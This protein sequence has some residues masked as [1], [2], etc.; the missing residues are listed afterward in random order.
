MLVIGLFRSTVPVLSWDEIATAD[1]AH[2]SP[3][4]I[5]AL[6]HHIDGVFGPYY[7]SM[8]A[9]IVVFGDSVLSLRLP[10]I[11]AMAV[12]A[13]LTAELGRRLLSPAAG[14]VAGLLLCLLPNV[15]RYAAEARPYAL[16]CMFSVLALLLLFRALDRPDL[17]RWVA[18][19]AANLLLGLFS[20]VAM[21]ALAGHF[22]ILVARRR[23][24]VLPWL[25][26][27]LGTGVV[28][29]PLIWWGVH[30][31][32]EQLHWVKPMTPGAVYTFPALLVGSTEAA[33]LLIGIVVLAAATAGR[34]I[35]DMTLAAALPLVLVCAIS[36]AGTSFWVNRYLL[37]MLLPT[38]IVAAAPL[39]DRT[40]RRTAPPTPPGTTPPTSPGIAPPSATPPTSPGIAPP[41]TTPPTSP[42]IAPP[43]PRALLPV[44]IALAV[45]AAAAAP[46]QLAVRQPTVKNGSDYR[47]LAATIVKRQ[48][49]GDDL[50]FQKG[51]TLRT[52]VEYYLRDD[53]GRPIDVLLKKSAAGTGT[54]VAEEYADSAAR[55]SGADRIWLIAYGKRTDPATSRPDL[56]PVLRDNYRRIGLWEVKGASMALYVKR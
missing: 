50:V 56:E 8:H 15:S 2:R 5:W 45:F 6:M 31:R 29:A 55:L 3:G 33:W 27:V 43:T 40:L 10:S 13:A 44:A 39:T 24:R 38:V 20:L 46:G 42:G 14:V 9:W 30:Q 12:A 25:A 17:G 49:P 52:G 54:L 32:R 47:A 48:R 36:F 21:T 53:A 23:T 35:L 7:L 18:Y 19:T 51:R 22:A 4:Q 26:A 37:F 41:S 28:L 1:V 11:L 34:S 16:A